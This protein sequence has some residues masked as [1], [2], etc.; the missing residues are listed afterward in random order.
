MPYRRI[1]SVLSFAVPQHIVSSLR[2]LEALRS[3]GD[4]DIVEGAEAIV[5]TVFDAALTVVLAL[6]SDVK[7]RT[8]TNQPMPPNNNN[9]PR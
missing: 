5:L 7:S 8:T 9:Q 4:V 3:E 6:T 1:V 2:F